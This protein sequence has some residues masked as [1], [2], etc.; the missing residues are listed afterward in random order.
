MLRTRLLATVPLLGGLLI[1]GFAHGQP[2]R[3]AGHISD[4]SSTDAAVRRNAV[5]ELGRL[6][7]WEAVAPLM[8]LLADA[9][10]AVRRE[11]RDALE[12]IGEDAVPALLEGLASEGAPTR[13]GCA[14]VLS[15]LDYLEDDRFEAA[16]LPLLKDPDREVRFEA[17]AALGRVGDL[18]ALEPLKGA[19]ADADPAVQTEAASS[20]ARLGDGAGYEV[21]LRGAVS[22]DARLR[23]RVV[24]P[25]AWIGTPAAL[26][27]I[28]DLTGDVDRDV[29]GAAYQ[30]LLSSG[31]PDAVRAGLDG[32]NDPAWQVRSHLAH[33]AG[34]F[35][36][37]ATA[38]PLLQLLAGD[39][40]PTVRTSAAMALANLRDLRAVPDL[41]KLLDSRS[42]MERAGGAA[43]LGLLRV[44]DAAPK[45]T[46]LLEDE[47]AEVRRSARLALLSILKECPDC[48]Q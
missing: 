29:R 15:R 11:A 24:E 34:V 37:T 35:Q 33:I 23:A 8:P 36:V 7:I 38:D 46:E 10:E 32:L 16:I 41:L 45:L 43:A 18:A 5:R 26:Q 40:S 17:A 4:L 13:A 21:L 27:T 20:L 47:A 14:D 2:D 3:L 22:P 48:P 6:A 39:A 28:V 25:L 9:E 31:A 1:G 30:A 19:L 42:E 44:K 12:Q